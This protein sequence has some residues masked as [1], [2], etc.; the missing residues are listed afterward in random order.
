[1]QS[2]NKWLLYVQII[3]INETKLYGLSEK[4]ILSEERGKLALVINH[5]R[6]IQKKL[7]KIYSTDS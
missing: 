4:E 3:F 7:N 2:T 6:I 1:M 5:Q